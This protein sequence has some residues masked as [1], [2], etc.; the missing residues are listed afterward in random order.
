MSVVRNQEGRFS[1]VAPVRRGSPRSALAAAHPAE[2]PP[3]R[4][5]RPIPPLYAPAHEHRAAKGRRL[6]DQEFLSVLAAP[7]PGPGWD[8]DEGGR[9]LVLPLAERD[10]A[11]VLESCRED[12]EGDWHP[13]GGGEA[14][15]FAHERDYAFARYL[16]L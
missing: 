1:A 9:F 5:G 4:A 11:S 10:R 15:V 2:G 12:A 6:S 13:L 8:L 3:S 7:E 16:T 14:V